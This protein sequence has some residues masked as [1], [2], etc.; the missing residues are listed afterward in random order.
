MRTESSISISLTFISSK[1]PT[2]IGRIG[3]MAIA[4]KH[5]WPCPVPTE[6][7]IESAGQLRWST[8][9]SIRARNSACIQARYN[10]DVRSRIPTATQ[11]PLKLTRTLT[12]KRVNRYICRRR[13]TFYSP[14]FRLAKETGNP[15]SSVPIT[16]TNPKPPQIQ[17]RTAN[18][19]PTPLLK[20][21][22]KNRVTFSYAPK[23]PRHFV[24]Y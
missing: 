18:Q 8:R 2:V 19:A 15:T 21:K 20:T 13:T 12:M 11:R 5:T 23:L 24:H 9:L 14:I 6:P 3:K 1:H 7:E 4:P 16:Q 22:I 10:S 17:H